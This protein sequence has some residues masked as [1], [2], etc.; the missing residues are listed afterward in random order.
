MDIKLHTLSEL[1]ESL[2]DQV[3]QSQFKVKRRLPHIHSLL[4]KYVQQKSHLR[5]LAEQKS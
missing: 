4:S 5:A 1:S 3:P 2:L